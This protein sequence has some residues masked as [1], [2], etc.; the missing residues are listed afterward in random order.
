VKARVQLAVTV[1][2]D[3]AAMAA[4][5]TVLQVNVL[6]AQAATSKVVA[7]ANA[8]HKV[9]VLAAAMAAAMAVVT[10]VETA[11]ALVVTVVAMTAAASETEMVVDTTHPRARQQVANLIL[12]VPAWT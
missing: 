10:G 7:P 4:A 5:A 1:V 11:A 3:A 8:Q 9:A 2:V 6:K 12:C